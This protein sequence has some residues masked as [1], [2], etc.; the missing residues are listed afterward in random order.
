MT[1]RRTT[2]GLSK[3]SRFSRSVRMCWMSISS[4]AAWAMFGFVGGVFGLPVA[5]DEV[6][7]VLEHAIGVDDLAADL[8]F[9]LGGKAG[10]VP[11]SKKTFCRDQ[12]WSRLRTMLAL[13][14]A[15]PR[16]TSC[17]FSSTERS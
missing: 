8:L 4:T 2:S 6:H 14:T 15:T 1:L 9:V 11:I 13:L 17:S 12:V 3:I 5:A 10:R 7:V 16:S